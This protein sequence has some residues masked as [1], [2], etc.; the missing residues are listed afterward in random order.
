MKANKNDNE[1]SNSTLGGVLSLWVYLITHKYWTANEVGERVLRTRQFRCDLHTAREY[2]KVHLG[3]LVAPGGHAVIHAYNTLRQLDWPELQTNV[4]ADLRRAW[5]WWFT[6]HNAA[7]DFIAGPAS[8]TPTM[9]L[10]ESAGRNSEF[11]KAMLRDGQSPLLWMYRGAQ[12]LV[13]W[14]YGIN[15]TFAYLQT[16]GL[17]G[18]MAGYLPNDNT[19]GIRHTPLYLMV[20]CPDVEPKNGWYGLNMP[21]YHDDGGCAHTSLLSVAPVEDPHK[22]TSWMVPP[23]EVMDHPWR[24]ANPWGVPKD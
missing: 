20:K 14:L 23:E 1:N 4:R 24:K 15:T 12:S 19:L 10:I 16:H 5:A 22:D 2:V 18:W 6:E 3:N 8:L 11:T 17:G 13:W 9:D 21:P 7:W